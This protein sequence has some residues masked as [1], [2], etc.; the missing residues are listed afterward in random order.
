MADVHRKDSVF[1]D[2]SVAQ[3]NEAIL[4]RPVLPEVM[5]GRHLGNIADA[6]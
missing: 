2:F 4:H 3:K 5:G 1:A 6:I